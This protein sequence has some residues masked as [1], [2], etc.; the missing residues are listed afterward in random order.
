[1]N[2]L[3]KAC[4]HAEIKSV[5]ILS[6]YFFAL[7]MNQA[8]INACTSACA[9]SVRYFEYHHEL[10]GFKDVQTWLNLLWNEFDHDS[11]DIGRLVSTVCMKKEVNNDVMT[12][13]LLNLPQ[14][15]IP[16]NEVLISCCHQRRISHVK[17]IFQKFDDKQLDI[18]QAFLHACGEASSTSIQS[19]IREIFDHNHM[20][21]VDFLFQKLLDHDDKA[22]NLSFVL[23]ELPE[24]NKHV[25]ILYFLEE[26][27]C[28]HLMNEACYHGHVKLVQWILVNVEYTNLDILDAMCKAFEGIKHAGRTKKSNPFKTKCVMCLALTWH[29]TQDVDILEILT[30]EEIRTAFMSDSD[31]DS[32][33]D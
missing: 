14:E 13:I 20:M 15:Q 11:V 24:T 32:F 28:K 5:K 27:F 12:W 25:I 10:K 21:L 8:M 6:K 17:Y 1:M 7:D 18:R 33:E 26:G 31:T 9:V 16:I 3:N 19:S 2:I 4:A 22:V 29:Y 23:I 30:V